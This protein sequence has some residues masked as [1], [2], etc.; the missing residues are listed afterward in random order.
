M[1]TRLTT[2]ARNAACD[3][4]VDLIDNGLGQGAIEIYQGAQPASA[5]DGVGASTLLGVVPFADPAF[6]GASAGVA[7][8]LGTPLSDAMAGADGIAQWFRVKDGAGATVF[9]GDI[10]TSA[11]GTGD[12]QLN[13]TTIEVDGPINI[14]SFTFTIP[15]SE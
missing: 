6:S 13:T 3:G 7:S 9:D 2:A 14:T 12:L 10:S 4:I 8:A 11:A 5:N 1:P 15:A